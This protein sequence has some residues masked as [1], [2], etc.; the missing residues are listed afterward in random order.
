MAFEVA[1]SALSALRQCKSGNSKISQ[2]SGANIVQCKSYA[3]QVKIFRVALVSRTVYNC[4]QFGGKAMSITEAAFFY[5]DF[6]ALFAEINA[7]EL[8]ENVEVTIPQD[9]ILTCFDNQSDL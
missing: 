9:K 8:S 1:K 3:S 5:N 7:A 6:S 2:V 4:F